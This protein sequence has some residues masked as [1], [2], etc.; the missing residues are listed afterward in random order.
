MPAPARILIVDSSAESRD[1]LSTLLRRQGLE[2]IETTGAVA[3]SLVLG[4]EDPDLIVYDAESE[5][6]PGCQGA[7]ALSRSASRTATPI[8]V[9]GT[10]SRDLSPLASG[11]F[12]SKPYHYR[13][14]IRRIESLLEGRNKASGW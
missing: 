1:I 13:P 11:Q 6:V 14:L 2:T 5:S 10:A 8:V 9:L 3:A 12:V 7:L 4:Q